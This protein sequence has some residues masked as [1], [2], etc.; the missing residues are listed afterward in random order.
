MT[1]EEQLSAAYEVVR[2]ANFIAH[3]AN[4]YA[5]EAARQLESA[6]AALEVLVRHSAT[7]EVS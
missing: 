1:T 7:R 5:A 3:G 6:K 2:I 4:T